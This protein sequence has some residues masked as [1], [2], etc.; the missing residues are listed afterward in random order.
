MESAFWIIGKSYISVVIPDVVY[1][2]GDKVN[3]VIEL[4]L[5]EKVKLRGVCLLVIGSEYAAFNDSGVHAKWEGAFI[6]KKFTF[7]IPVRHDSYDSDE[8]NGFLDKGV[9]RIPFTVKLPSFLPPSCDFCSGGMKYTFSA[10]I[11]QGNS[12]QFL[13]K[14][15]NIKVGGEL[16]DRAILKPATPITKEHHGESSEGG[17]QITATIPKNYL[18]VDEHLKINILVKNTSKKSFDFVKIS[19]VQNRK[20]VAN[21]REYNKTHKEDAWT[22]TH[23][24]KFPS[25]TN[26]QC[27]LD[28]VI[29]SVTPS[30]FTTAEGSSWSPTG[31]FVS[32]DLIVK[33]QSGSEVRFPIYVMVP[34]P[35]KPIESH[36]P[37]HNNAR[38]RSCTTI[39]PDIDGYKYPDNIEPQFVSLV[40]S[41]S[42]LLNNTED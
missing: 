10:Y 12:E 13:K 11:D 28:Y 40:T 21:S 27:D 24:H 39:I 3:G 17:L 4:N 38:G 14:A 1:F 18:C 36:D 15:V 20:H 19:L 33:L 25:K 8:R 6:S 42:S 26:N 9:Y 34:N 41:S 5:F 7:H 2:G 23:K 35:R 37:V 29:P 32:Y 22:T 31:L 16:F 30:I